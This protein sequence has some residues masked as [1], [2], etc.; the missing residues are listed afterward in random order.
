M[1]NETLSQKAAK[2]H[3]GVY[4]GDFVLKGQE[5][6]KTHTHVN[7]SWLEKCV[8]FDSF[9]DTVKDVQTRFKDL[10]GVGLSDLKCKDGRVLLGE[11]G[12]TLTPTEHSE[13]QLGAYAGVPAYYLETLRE[14]NDLELYDLNVN[15][16][17][18]RA[19]DKS[20]NKGLFIRARNGANGEPQVL[21]ALL[22]SRYATINNAP[23]VETLADILPGGKIS[24]LYYD[25]DTF[26]ANVLI[27]DTLRTENDSD[28]GGG[29]SVL[30]NETGR[31]KY[32]S[33]PFVFRAIC[34]NGNIWDEVKGQTYS[35]R[36]I[37]NIDWADFR[38]NLALNIQSQIPMAQ[39]KIE[40]VL[41]LKGMPVTEQVI[42][43]AIVYLGRREGMNEGTQQKWLEGF[44]TELR[45]AKSAKDILSAFGLVQGLTRAAQDEDVKFEAREMMETLSARLIDANMDKTLTA[46]VNAVTVEEAQEVLIG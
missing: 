8:S 23:V 40:R 26:R 38:R 18:A 17:L 45:A 12:I 21:R 34:F 24:H 22:S 10:E 15:K 25:G 42:Q 35:R 43:Q 29:V 20:P 3:S 13:R 28:Y 7:A 30:N 39:A 41:A 46:A 11:S 27:P 1:T 44:R 2:Q 32:V 31:F 33:R 4:T 16:G 36:H 5:M 37:G 19:V 6:S 9:L 14:A